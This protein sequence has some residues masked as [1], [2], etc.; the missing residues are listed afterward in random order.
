MY[1]TL[2]LHGLIN[3][4][5]YN[6][7]YFVMLVIRYLFE[8]M[9]STRRTKPATSFPR[10]RGAS[11]YT[12]A[13]CPLERPLGTKTIKERA[14]GLFEGNDQQIYTSDASCV[15]IWQY[16]NIYTYIRIYIYFDISQYDTQGCVSKFGTLNDTWRIAILRPCF[17]RDPITSWEC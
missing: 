13:W 10:P 8:Y 11:L 5:V 16:A 4:L 7:P 2:V 12:L 14:R 6:R 1:G 9:L 17:P 3:G 15:L